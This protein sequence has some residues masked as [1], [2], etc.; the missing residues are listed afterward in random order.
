M[1]TTPAAPTP[2]TAEAPPPAAAPHVLGDATDMLIDRYLSP[3]ET[4]MI[5]HAVV[6]ADV[7]TTWAALM[8]LDLM[9]VHSPLLDAAFALR[10]LP[11]KLSGWFG[12][13]KPSSPPP[14]ELKLS[15]DGP[16]LDGWMPLGQVP[17]TEVVVGAIG[18]FWQ[19]DIT[20]YDVGAMTPEAFAG[21]A[22]AGWGRIAAGF[23]LRPYGSRRTLVSYEART[24]TTDRRSAARF[25]WYWRL[26]RPFVGHV[27]RA[28]LA[29]LQSQAHEA[30]AHGL[31]QPPPA[32]SSPTIV[33]PDGP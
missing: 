25:A 18:R 24:A 5:E 20:W 6:D 21:F 8:D 13:D 2:P 27:M 4:T 29:E 30:A 28:A 15:A 22:E 19:P 1:P 11:A 16:A 10:G 26:V 9:A 3:Y 31:H 33:L 14:A 17:G 7:E 12:A 23:S 32:P